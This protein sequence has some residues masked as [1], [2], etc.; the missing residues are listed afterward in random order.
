MAKGLSIPSPVN[1]IGIYQMPEGPSWVVVWV[2][3]VVLTLAYL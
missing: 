2:A 3:R 1:A